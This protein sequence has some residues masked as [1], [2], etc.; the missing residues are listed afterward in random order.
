MRN[1]VVLILS[2]SNGSLLLSGRLMVQSLAL[3]TCFF[4]QDAET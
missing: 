3:L 1:F 4:G 2:K